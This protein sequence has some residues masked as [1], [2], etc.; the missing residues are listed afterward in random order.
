MERTLAL[1]KPDAVGQGKIGEI[2]R[3]FEGQGLRVVGLKMVFLKQQ[4][5]VGFYR[6][7]QDKPFFQGLIEFI[8]SGP[9]I[10]M[11]LEGEEVIS[12]V[13]ELMGSTDPAEAK[14]GTIRR[15]MG[16]S[17]QKNAVHGSDSVESADREIP[18]FFNQMEIFPA[19][20]DRA[21]EG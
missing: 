18:F 11:V 5:G 3:R 13:R 4:E 15:Q 8:T 14:E 20:S 21:G 6:V 16:T 1:I 17:V 10:A 9:I 7:H 19:A 2:I 12:R